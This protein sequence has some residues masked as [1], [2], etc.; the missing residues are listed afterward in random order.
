VRLL[1][2]PNVCKGNKVLISKRNNENT[3]CFFT[4]IVW[5]RCL[6]TLITLFTLSAKIHVD[7]AVFEFFERVYNSEFILL[8]T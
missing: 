3:V 8:V 6:C 2:F 7:F 4:F 5:V 1:A